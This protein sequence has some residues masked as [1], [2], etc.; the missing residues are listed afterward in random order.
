MEHQW[1]IN[2]HLEHKW[3]RIKNSEMDPQL[4]GQLIFDK[5]GKNVQRKKVYST[6]DVGKSGQQHAEE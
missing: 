1:N 5:V 3:N 2:E 6:N 4:Y